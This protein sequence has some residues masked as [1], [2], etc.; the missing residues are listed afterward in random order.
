VNG[1]GNGNGTPATPT[2][3][4][5]G[6]IPIV[7]QPTQVI[8]GTQTVAVPGTGIG[9][10][11]SGSGSGSGSGS[12]NG[13]GTGTSSGT[14]TGSGT[15]ASSG[16]NNG[17]GSGSGTGS[18][19]GGGSGNSVTTEPNG[20]KVV[21]EGGQTFTIN[22]SQ[23]IGSGT[24][25]N[26]PGTA[27]GGVF[28]ESP[29]PTIISG[30][31]VQIGQSVAVISGTTYSIGPGAPQTT[32]VV[33]GQTISVGP[34]GLGFAQTTVAPAGPLP[35][36]VVIVEGEVFSAIG[37]SVAVIGGSTITY[38]GSIPATTDVFNGASITLGP[39]GI[40]FDSSTLGGTKNPTNT[41]L[42]IAGG[43]S[44]TEIGS[45]IAVISGMTF[46]VGPGAIPT[47]TVINGHT[48]S[49]G[50]SGLGLKGTTLSYPFN[51]TTRTITAGGVTYSEIAGTLVVFGGTTFTV[52]PGA[53]PTTDI[54]NGQT[55]SIGPGGV[56]FSTTT[57]PPATSTPTSASSAK[58][59]GK[60]NGG[61]TLRP[62]GSGVLGVCIALCMGL[63]FI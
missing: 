51:P 47:S 3:A 21:V 57:I 12:N 27:A 58:A 15:G 25:I 62:L 40:Q 43:L 7:V 26:I 5:V 45:T 19:T 14:G 29:T 33:N 2:T 4:T 35:T 38:G 50:P 11:S 41:Q 13:A 22:P 31:P 53:K 1:N 6:G 54:Y 49:V 39:T 56:G 61:V 17:V 9:G 24:T 60:K 63:N 42:G 48:I 16:N 55:I 30:V 36:N 44:I 8:I 20:N 18:G 52:G 23:V 46:T 10:A 37:P 59:T 32:I 28:R 34:S